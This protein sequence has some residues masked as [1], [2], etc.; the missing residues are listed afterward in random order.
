MIELD[1]LDQYSA[2][3]VGLP[4]LKTPFHPNLERLPALVN[5]P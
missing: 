3:A 5:I 4:D 2:L 1:A